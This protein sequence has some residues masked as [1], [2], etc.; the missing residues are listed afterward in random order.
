[1]RGTATNGASGTYVAGVEK[2]VVG[3]YALAVGA[4][5]H[6]EAPGRNRRNML[7]PVPVMVIGRLG[8]DQ[9]GSGPGAGSGSP[10]GRG[11]AYSTGSRDCWNSGYV[12]ACPFGARPTL[13]REVGVY[14][15][16]G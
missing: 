9:T 7:D 14:C 11:I 12:G 1:M 6:S 8:V 5:A 15:F 13:L 10:A 2:R 3:Y 4:V 16:A